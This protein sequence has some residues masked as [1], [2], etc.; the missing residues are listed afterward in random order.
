MRARKWA[1]AMGAATLV[2]SAGCSASPEPSAT[3]A[4][5][6]PAASADSASPS[7]AAPTAPVGTRPVVD[8]LNGTYRL[9]RFADVGPSAAY[10]SGRGGDVELRFSGE[11]FPDGNYVGTAYRV[12]AA[13]KRS[14]ALTAPDG[15]PST[16]VS[17]VRAVG[18]YTLENSEATFARRPGTGSGRLTSGGSTRRLDLAEVLQIVT[19][20]GTLTVSC[21]RTTLWLTGES[22]QYELTAT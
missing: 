14:M 22:V 10:R 7:A 17:S 6:S 2:V 11:E 16:L 21:T 1:W 20:V 19:P 15:T 9:T 18:S 4:T 8:C 3:T 12:V 5:V 13:A